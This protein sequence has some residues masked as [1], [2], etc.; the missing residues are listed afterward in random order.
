MRLKQSFSKTT[1]TIILIMLFLAV[2]GFSYYALIL[3]NSL[4]SVPETFV[5]RFYSDLNN[6][7]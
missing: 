1:S 2:L 5:D 3:A 6:F 7:N 4:T